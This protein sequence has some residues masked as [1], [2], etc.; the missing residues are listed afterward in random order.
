MKDKKP[1]PPKI[2]RPPRKK[3]GL[4]LAYMKAQLRLGPNK[5]S[6]IKH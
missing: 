2:S 5:K 4:G 3:L 6:E 1:K